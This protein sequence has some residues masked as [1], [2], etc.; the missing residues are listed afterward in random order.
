MYE[1]SFGDGAS[2][3][4][5]STDPPALIC[6]KSTATFP[7]SSV[8]L[9]SL[10]FT[11]RTGLIAKQSETTRRR[12]RRDTVF[13]VPARKACEGMIKAFNLRALFSR[14]DKSSEPP[15]TIRPLCSNIHPPPVYTISGLLAQ[16]SL[17]KQRRKLCSSGRR[18]RIING[19]G[20][21]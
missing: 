13:R 10:K 5:I 19:K 20:Y 1:Y 12:G 21:F 15:R 4:N 7:H 18:A 11:A 9:T 16:A 8:S 3:S 6:S 2:M 17:E 14:I